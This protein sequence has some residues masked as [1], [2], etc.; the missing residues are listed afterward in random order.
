MRMFGK[1]FPKPIRSSMRLMTEAG[2]T[3]TRGAATLNYLYCVYAEYLKWR[4][5]RYCDTIAAHLEGQRGVKLRNPRRCFSFMVGQSRV[6]TS[7]EMDQKYITLLVYARNRKMNALALKEFVGDKCGSIAK[8]LKYIDGEAKRKAREQ[9]RARREA[10]RKPK[11]RVGLGWR[12]P[13][14]KYKRK[15]RTHEALMN[16]WPPQVNQQANVLPEQDSKMV[17]DLANE[18]PTVLHAACDQV[19]D[20]NGV[21]IPI[22]K[23]FE[24]D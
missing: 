24:E 15:Q 8:A 5:P 10:A 19:F 16:P 4:R 7:A 3:A 14:R 13:A 1:P 9:A 6:S 22:S 20:F 17:I 18:T 21:L 12:R 23:S 11:P 2:T